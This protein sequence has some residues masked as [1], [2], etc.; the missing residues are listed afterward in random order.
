MADQKVTAL[1]ALTTP[2]NDDIIPLV[3]DPSGTPQTKKITYANFLAAILAAVPS[4]GIPADGWIAGTGTWTY[5]SADSPTFTLTVNADL[6]GVIQK[7][8]R[9]KLTQTTAKYFIVT[10]I[11]Y[12]APNTTI[13]LYGGTDYT[14][15]NAAITSPY[16]SPTKAPFGF[17]MDPAKWSVRVADGSTYSQ[18]TPTANTWYN[19]GSVSIT[20]P[21]GSWDVLYQS[22][23][24][25]D[26]GGGGGVASLISATLS[27]A[28]NSESDSEFTGDLY[29]ELTGATNRYVGGT[30]F[31]REPNMILTSKTTYYLNFKTP[32]ASTAVIYGYTRILYARCNYL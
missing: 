19:L 12:S 26:R 6:T 23:Q 3:D 9:I 32:V 18:A 28:N 15:A 17:P 24:L 22:D 13:T 8:H 20:I 31:R 11:S 7:G 5:A 29:V 16:Y 1:T 14:L 21:I 25:S 10:N 4:S 30:F 27:T 2:S